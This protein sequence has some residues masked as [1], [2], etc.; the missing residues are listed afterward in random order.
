VLANRTN[1]EQVATNLG[2]RHSRWQLLLDTH[3]EPLQQL[4]H[5]RAV[6]IDL[7]DGP[8]SSIR[9]ALPTMPWERTS[10]RER[11]LGFSW[12]L[13]FDLGS[14]MARLYLA[15]LGVERWALLETLRPE[16][17]TSVKDVDH[18]I[19][20]EYFALP[21]LEWSVITNQPAGARS[22]TELWAIGSGAEIG[23][24]SVSAEIRAH[25]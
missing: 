23:T 22:A 15:H 19:S 1:A 18:A 25:H 5:A 4:G 16:Q 20:Q 10:R 24:G 12:T 8:A 13:P 21:T 9:W 7:A 2:R 14:E 6:R 17:T 11:I 3:A